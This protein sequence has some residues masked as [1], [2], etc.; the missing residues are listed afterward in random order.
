[1]TNLGKNVEKSERNPQ[2]HEQDS[3]LNDSDLFKR[4]NGSNMQSCKAEF[5]LEWLNFKFNGRCGVA[6]SLANQW[7]R[8]LLIL[9]SMVDIHHEKFKNSLGFYHLKV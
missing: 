1:V 2:I 6:S 4:F 5:D 8:Y 9:R 3:S 7:S